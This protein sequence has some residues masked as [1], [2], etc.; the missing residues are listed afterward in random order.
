MTKAIAS[1]LVLSLLHKNLLQDN[2]FDLLGNMGLK[3]KKKP[4]SILQQIST[5]LNLPSWGFGPGS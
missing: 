2:G 5:A 4:I 1:S 3:K